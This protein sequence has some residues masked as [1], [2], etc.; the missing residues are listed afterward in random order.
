[1]KNI[2]FVDDQADLWIDR[3]NLYLA[4]H[5]L[6]FFK[7][8]NPRRCLKRIRDEKPDAVLLDIMFPSATRRMAAIGKT[9]LADIKKEF[10]SLPVIM[11][12]T[13]L[14]DPSINLKEGDYPGAYSMFAKDRFEEDSAEA[15]SELADELLRAITDAAAGTTG[16]ERKMDFVVG[17]SARMVEIA[18]TIVKVSA[19]NTAILI[20]GESG[21]GKELIARAIHQL[22]P[23]HN[24]PFMVLNCGAIPHSLLESE[25]FGHDKGA[26]TGARTQGHAGLFERGQDGTVFLDEV[27]NM[28][29][30]TQR[31]VLRVLQDQ[32]ITRLGGTKSINVNIRLISATNRNL[33]NE[34]EKGAFRAD[35]YYRLKVVEIDLPPLRERNSDIPEL[36]A[37]FVD[38]LNRKLGKHIST[39][40][41]P[42]LHDLLRAYTWPGNIRELENT[43]ESAMVTT[44]ANVLTPGLFQLDSNSVDL[45][46]DVLRLAKELLEGQLD[47][48]GLKDIHGTTRGAILVEL[49]K[50]VERKNRKPPTSAQ[51]AEILRI[52]D[53]NMRRILSQSGISLRSRQ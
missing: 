35:L 25:L 7:E 44:R 14:T 3:F 53:A 29:A 38:K 22:S 21:T 13:T 40:L 47:W 49:V 5:G 28:S 37:H 8:V 46:V 34:V 30:E 24:G 2:L 19:H 36:F 33:T 39:K 42:D 12:T 10:P 17:T 18:E 4:G 23:R 27:Q 31:A 50:L 41:R 11:I 51:L 45:V 16:H 20:S 32:E 26:F 43:I 52:N 9:V 15:A 6:Q 48:S 1:M